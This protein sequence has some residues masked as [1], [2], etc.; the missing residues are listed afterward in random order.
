MWLTNDTALESTLM[1]CN[2]FQAY[3]FFKAISNDGVSW[4]ADYTARDVTWMPSFAYEA[5]GL[6]TGVEVVRV[7]GEYRAYYSSWS[8]NNIPDPNIYLC[9]D[10]NGGFIPAISTLNLATWSN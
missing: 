2:A 7:N 5:N 1:P 10:Q 6:F 3:G 9:P 8:N 4:T